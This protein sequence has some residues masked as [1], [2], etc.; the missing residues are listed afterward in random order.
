MRHFELDGWKNKT[1]F[2]KD[3]LNMNLFVKSAANL[4]DVK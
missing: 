3:K 1:Y 4:N 2:M